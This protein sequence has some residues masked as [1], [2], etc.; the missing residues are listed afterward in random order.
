[1]FSL[2]KIHTSLSADRDGSASA[3][4]LSMLY[5]RQLLDASCPLSYLITKGLPLFTAALEIQ[6]SLKNKTFLKQK[7]TNNFE[8]IH[9]WEHSE[10][11]GGKANSKTNMKWFSIYSASHLAPYFFFCGFVPDPS[12][13]VILS[14]RTTW[15]I[16]LLT[17]K[18]TGIFFFF[19]VLNATTILSFS[20]YT[21]G[22]YHNLILRFIT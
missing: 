21:L 16:L 15:K 10:F 8:M 2:N 9:M 18:K 5:F 19:Y 11:M 6:I 22:L 14:N 1:M 12:P 20:L 3:S 17:K 13:P 7:K 4:V